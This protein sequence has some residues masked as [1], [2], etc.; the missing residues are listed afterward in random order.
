MGVLSHVIK[1]L[2]KPLKI[3]SYASINMNVIIIIT[4]YWL[5][6]M[7]KNCAKNHVHCA[8]DISQKLFNKYHYPQLTDEKTEEI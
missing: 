7:A 2:I 5:C 6:S 1:G 3:V 8:I 4:G